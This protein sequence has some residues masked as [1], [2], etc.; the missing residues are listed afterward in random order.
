MVKP[1]FGAAVGGRKFGF[2]NSKIVISKGKTLFF[3]RRRRE[4]I[5]LETK[6]SRFL[7]V[8]RP[9][10]FLIFAQFWDFAIR[11]IPVK[12]APLV[13]YFS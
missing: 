2:L 13:K 6:K 7:R 10:L 3:G 4:K 1:C 9:K 11:G 5:R 8:K 12:K